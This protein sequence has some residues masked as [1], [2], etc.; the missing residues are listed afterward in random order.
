MWYCLVTKKI[1]TNV[2]KGQVYGVDSSK[3]ALDIARK[4]GRKETKHAFH[5][6]RC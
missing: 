4:V 2:G 5:S 1:L 3:S 6:W